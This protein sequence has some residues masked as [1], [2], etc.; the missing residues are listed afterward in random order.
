[1]VSDM[2]NQIFKYAA[3]LNAV[4]AAVMLIPNLYVG[5]WLGA[6][7]FALLAVFS[8]YNYRSI[9]SLI[10]EHEVLDARIAELKND[11]RS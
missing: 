1:M 8:M 7:I 3:L 6:L 4:V 2:I 11:Y 10:K 9:T 5:D